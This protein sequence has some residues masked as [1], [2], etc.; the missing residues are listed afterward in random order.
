MNIE[1]RLARLQDEQL[2]RLSDERIAHRQI[3]SRFLLE[4]FRS[5]TAYAL[6]ALR[7]AILINGGAAI[8][9]LAFLQTQTSDELTFY[10]PTPFAYALGCYAFGT[11]AATVG[12]AVG[13]FYQRD[14]FLQIAAQNLW[15]DSMLRKANPI[16]PNP[17]QLE[18]MEQELKA[19]RKEL[20]NPTF[21]DENLERRIVV[22]GLI[23]VV[24]G[25]L[26]IAAFVFGIFASWAAIF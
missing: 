21:G 7:T 9:L 11:I 16:V 8:A 23:S 1:E 20:E 13:F 4:V 19:A 17:D 24:A 10:T 25:G 15:M 2:L 18:K 26:S 5:T 3:M 22:L 12:T 14:S 6:T